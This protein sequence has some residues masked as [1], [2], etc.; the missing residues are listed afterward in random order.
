MM[1]RMLGCISM[2][3]LLLA[4]CAGQGAPPTDPERQYADD[5]SFCR[6]A[7]LQMVGNPEA[8]DQCMAA[9]GWPQRPPTPPPR[10]TP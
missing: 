7:T 9:R 6:A 1:R 5:T 2:I 10:V 3:G 8:F 4:G